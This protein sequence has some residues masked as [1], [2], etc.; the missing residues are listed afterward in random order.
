MDKR[1]GS[2]Y[3]NSRG[4]RPMWNQTAFGCLGRFGSENR[5]HVTCA[6]SDAKDYCVLV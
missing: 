2:M 3:L 5:A 1:V 4:K 6:H